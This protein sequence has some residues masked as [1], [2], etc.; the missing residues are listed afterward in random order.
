MMVVPG[1]PFQR[2]Q[3]DGFPRFPGGVP[4]NQSRLVQ[5]VDRFGQ[6]IVL[7]VGQRKWRPPGTLRWSARWRTVSDQGSCGRHER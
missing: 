3:F 4:M 6:R 5:A 1:D 2:C 7:A